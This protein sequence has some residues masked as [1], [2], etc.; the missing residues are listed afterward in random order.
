MSGALAEVRAVERRGEGDGRRGK[1]EKVGKKERRVRGN[2]ISIYIYTHNSRDIPH[3]PI[4][5]TPFTLILKHRDMY[6]LVL[7]DKQGHILIYIRNTQTHKPD[8]YTHLCITG[9][10]FI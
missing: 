5:P 9:V 8:T 7:H 2:T 3:K 4:S 6:T 10:S 1:G